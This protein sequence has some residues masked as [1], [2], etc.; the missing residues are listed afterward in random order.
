MNKNLHIQTLRGL[1]CVLLVLYHVIGSNEYHGLLVTDGLVRWF[2]D[3]LA[4]LRMP[5]FT[6]LSGLVYGLRPFK[7]GG[8]SRAF[9]VGKARRLLVPMLV[10][11]TL[12]ALIQ[13]K[14]PGT[15]EGIQHWYLIHIIPVAHYWFLESLLWIFVLIWL[16]ELSAILSRPS[17]YAL[18]WLASMILYLAVRGP[19]EFGITG[20]IYL[21]PY[22]LAGLAV[23]RFDLWTA[24]S[25]PWLR[26]ILLLL[27]VLSVVWMGLPQPD[28][29]RRALSILVAGMSLC[30]LC[31]SLPIEWPWLARIGTYSYAIYLFHVF[32]TAASRIVLINLGLTMFSVQLVAGLLLG[33]L[34]PMVVD[35]VASRYRWPALLLVGKSQRKGSNSAGPTSRDN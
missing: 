24:L 12:F 8:N 17:G 33:L 2:N 4:Y 15:H 31:L 21:L 19:R 7:R 9:L 29:D 13:S 11:G 10:V 35:M 5:L 18:I 1:A 3:G 27:A 23:T 20:A 14:T 34:G 28:Q 32:F 22:F 16:L 30:G 25:R 26:G 6:V